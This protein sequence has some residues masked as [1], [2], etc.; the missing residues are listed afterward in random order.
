VGTDE[1]EDEDE[2]GG[3]GEVEGRGG[4]EARRGWATASG[5]E[6]IGNE[7]S[8]AVDGSHCPTPPPPPPWYDDDN[9]VDGDDVNKL[10]R[11]GEDHGCAACCWYCCWW[12]WYWGWLWCCWS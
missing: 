5:D 9:D 2:G 3:D 6:G 12:Y 1:E 8:D 10:P 4:A 7:G 11:K